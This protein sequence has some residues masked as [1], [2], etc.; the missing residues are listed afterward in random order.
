MRNKKPSS[1]RKLAKDC[2]GRFERFMQE[3]NAEA[4]A[5]RTAEDAEAEAFAEKYLTAMRRKLGIEER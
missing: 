1:K 4:A 5:R 3:F 2:K